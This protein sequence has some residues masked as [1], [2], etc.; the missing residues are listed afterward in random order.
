MYPPKITPPL[1]PPLMYLCPPGQDPTVTTNVVSPMLPA[2]STPLDTDP[3]LAGSQC[4]GI[5]CSESGGCMFP[6]PLAPFLPSSP[7]EAGIP[8]K[9]W[10]HSTDSSLKG[11][12]PP[13][14]GT[15]QG[16]GRYWGLSPMFPILKKGSPALLPW[17]MYQRSVSH[18][19]TARKSWITAPNYSLSVSDFSP[20]PANLRQK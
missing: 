19:P 7:P 13:C 5:W 10:R 9:P 11:I 8:K 18:P 1:V 3:V 20:L 12:R 17:R 16:S 14:V 2:S 6:P 4:T 15:P